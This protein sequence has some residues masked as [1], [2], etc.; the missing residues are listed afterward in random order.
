MLTVHPGVPLGAVP[1]TALN[2]PFG[3]VSLKTT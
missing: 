2:I 1:S 3:F